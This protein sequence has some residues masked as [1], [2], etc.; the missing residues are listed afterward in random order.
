MSERKGIKHYR[1]RLPE[2]LWE[3]FYRAFPGK[4]E[5]SIV[6]KRLIKVAVEMQQEDPEGF[7]E[8]VKQEAL[9]RFGEEA[10]G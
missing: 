6:L 4:G 7:Y 3:E 9:A 2:A 8:D 10:D 1:L 5:R